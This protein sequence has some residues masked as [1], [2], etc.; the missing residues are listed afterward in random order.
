[1]HR[2][3]RKSDADGL[4][5]KRYVHSDERSAIWHW[6]SG[7]LGQHPGLNVEAFFCRVVI[8][9]IYDQSSDTRIKAFE[10][11]E[12]SLSSTKRLT[13]MVS[14][15]RGLNFRPFNFPSVNSC[16]VLCTR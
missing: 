1:M 7:P 13:N 16:M 6:A 11:Q 12:I 2:L 8:L 4:E 14:T 5:G 10:V 9:A 3:G 15:S